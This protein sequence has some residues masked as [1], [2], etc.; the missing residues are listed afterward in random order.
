M[1]SK[2]K[3]KTHSGPEEQVNPFAAVLASALGIEAPKGPGISVLQEEEAMMLGVKEAS[4]RFEK[5]GRNGKMATLI[6]F[7]GLNFS[8]LTDLAKQLKQQLGVGGSAD[9][10]GFVLLQ[11][12]VRN[13]VEKILQNEGWKTKRIGG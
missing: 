3:D 2:R 8:D 13:K 7:A 9:E 11:G 4:L 1:G 5:K 6:E 12:D 10:S